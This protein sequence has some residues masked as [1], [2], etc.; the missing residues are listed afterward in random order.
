MI[1]L[2]PLS[3]KLCCQSESAFDIREQHRAFMNKNCEI[4]VNE[5][6]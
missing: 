4:V 6:D 1:G 2:I 3:A 5:K